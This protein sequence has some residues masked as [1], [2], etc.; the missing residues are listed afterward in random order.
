MK[1]PATVKIGLPAVCFWNCRVL[2]AV[3]QVKLLKVVAPVMVDVPV[4]SKVT[5]PEECVKVPE[6]VQ[7]PATVKEA[8]SEATRVPEAAMVT[9]PL[10]S[11]TGSLV[12]R[13]KVPVLVPF[14]TVR[15]L[16]TVNVPL[17]MAVWV[18]PLADG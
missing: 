2:L 12:S 13:L 1:V 8:E 14:P 9:L 6:L 4:V 7:L 10:T 11:N 3:T 16:D 5:V 18:M 17:P 15:L